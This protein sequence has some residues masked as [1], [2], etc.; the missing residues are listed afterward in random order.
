MVPV[1]N[2]FASGGTRPTRYA[3]ALAVTVLALGLKLALDRWTQNVSPFL[4]FAAAVMFSAWFGGFG[5]GLVSTAAGALAV[6]YFL[7]TPAAFSTPGESDATRIMVFVLVGVQI[8]WLSG[9]LHNANRELEQ[10]VRQRTAELAVQKTLLESQ[11][12]ASRDGILAVSGDG[13]VIF[14]NRRFREVWGLAP[15]EPASPLAA[16]RAAMRERLAHRVD[17]LAPA[18]GDG[19]A[20][21]DGS[22]Q[23]LL[24]DGRVIEQYSAPIVAS[25]GESYGRVWF[26]RDITERRRLEKQILEAG[27]RERQNIGQDLHDDLCQQLT[28]IACLAA[29]HRQRLAL[30]SAEEADDAARILELVQQATARSRNLA[31]GLQPVTLESEGLLSALQELCSQV[32]ALSGVP[33]RFSGDAAPCCDDSAVPTHLYRIAQEAVTNAV[34]HARARTICVDVVRAGDRVILSVEDDG[35]GIP[36]ALVPGGI[37]LQS[38]A[39][40][41]RMIGASLSVERSSGGGTVVTCSLINPA[42]APAPAPAPPPRAAPA[43]ESDARPAHA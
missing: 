39:H 18:A 29:V 5:P 16:V 11:I 43:R 27:E 26:F 42:P 30:R 31:R 40:R 28:G 7:L 15:A 35:V 20:I 33:C 41:A 1:P 6:D 9:A 8:S 21:G 12:E 38:M 14:A 22:Q 36:D 2:M 23:A 4:F 37:G 3:L 24:A 17:V 25:G 34:K 19:P 13:Q 10:R 32:Q